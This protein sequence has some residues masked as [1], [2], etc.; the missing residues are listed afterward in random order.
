MNMPIIPDL[1]VTPHAVEQFRKRI[2]P[3][4]AAKARQMILDGF[5]QST[6]VRELPDGSTLR[7]RTRRPF[8]FEFRAYC[9]FDVERGHPVVATIVCGDSN[10][11]RKHRRKAVR[12]VEQ[13]RQNL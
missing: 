12:E 6:D 7:V 8:P 4:D 9:T 1:F 2:A 10:V 5:C 13:E 11:T 3:M